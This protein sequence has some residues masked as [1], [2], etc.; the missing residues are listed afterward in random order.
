MCL[1]SSGWIYWSHH[2]IFYSVT[3]SNVDLLLQEQV[4]R[5]HRSFLSIY[6]EVYQ[7]HPGPFSSSE[8]SH[9]SKM[10]ENKINQWQTETDWFEYL[11]L[12]TITYESRLKFSVNSQPEVVWPTCQRPFQRCSP[13]TPWWWVQRFPLHPSPWSAQTLSSESS[14]SVQQQL[15]LGQEPGTIN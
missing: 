7:R 12:W 9:I 2:K 4:V 8:Q 6:L 1:K 14:A 13:Q 5:A 15:Q 11:S 3:G 10:T